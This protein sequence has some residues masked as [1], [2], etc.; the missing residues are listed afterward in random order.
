MRKVQKFLITTIMCLGLFGIMRAEE[1]TVAG[2][3]V[4]GE[5]STR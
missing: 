3:T 2:V 1:V 5:F 4:N